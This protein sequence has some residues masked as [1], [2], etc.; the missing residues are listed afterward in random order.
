MEWRDEMQGRDGKT[1]WKGEVKEWEVRMGRRKRKVGRKQWKDGR[2][3]DTEKEGGTERRTGTAE[4]K[5]IDKRGNR[6]GGQGRKEAMER[7]M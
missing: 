2:A 6:D 4:L 7:G 1:K 5:R 3:G